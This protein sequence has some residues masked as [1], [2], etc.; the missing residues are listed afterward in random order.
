MLL[1]MCYHWESIQ[2]STDVI[3]IILNFCLTK[4]L[5]LDFS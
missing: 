5:F 1:S 2:W 3:H 4:F